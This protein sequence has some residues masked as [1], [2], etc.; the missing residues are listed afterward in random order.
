MAD[1]SEQYAAYRSM[2]QAY[3]RG[4]FKFGDTCTRCGVSR[5]SS[6][7]RC[8][9]HEHHEDYSKPLETITLCST[10]HVD[11]H[12]QRRAEAEITPAD[13]DVFDMD[14][15]KAYLRDEKGY[16]RRL[17]YEKEDHHE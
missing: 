11:L 5:K 8:V 9:L 7:Y 13:A 4:E 15:Y 3:E 10:C 17:R 12:Q 2:R 16:R 6:H 14:G 1:K